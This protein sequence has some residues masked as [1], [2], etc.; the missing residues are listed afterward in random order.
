M[1]PIKELIPY[2]T[3][4][5]AIAGFLFSLVNFI[6][7]KVVVSKITQNDLKHLEQDVDTLKKETKDYKGEHQG[8]LEKI[9]RRLGKIEKAIVKRDAICEERHKR[10]KR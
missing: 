2:I 8:V 10:D 9:F 3:L 7:R 4:F 1:P 6:V 5:I